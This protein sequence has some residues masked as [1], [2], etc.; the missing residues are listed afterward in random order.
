VPKVVVDWE[1]CQN[2]G[3]CLFEAPDV[4]RFDARDRLYVDEGAE[5]PEE[6]VE[7]VEAAMDVCPM[8][9]ISL[10]D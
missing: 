10:V 2:Y 4:F 9:A 3:Q 6:L 5:L 1:R 8:Q 7:G